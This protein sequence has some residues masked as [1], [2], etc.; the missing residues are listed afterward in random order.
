MFK[1]KYSLLLLPVLSALFC[2]SFYEPLSLS[3]S[4]H[5]RDARSAICSLCASLFTL[6]LVSHFRETKLLA[7]IIHPPG[8]ER[9]CD[10]GAPGA[11][12]QPGQ[13]GTERGSVNPK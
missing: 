3:L 4:Q 8:G 1:S 7:Q 5:E 12:G 13:E 11:G 10:G 6:I 2:G 9:D